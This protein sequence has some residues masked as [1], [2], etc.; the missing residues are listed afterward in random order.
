MRGQ[1]ATVEEEAVPSCSVFERE[2]RRRVKNSDSHRFSQRNDHESG[3]TLE[4]EWNAKKLNIASI[5][6]TTVR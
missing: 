5:K 1:M 2:G 6:R 3:H 4:R